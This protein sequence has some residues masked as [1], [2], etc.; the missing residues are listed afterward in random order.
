MNGNVDIAREK[1]TREQLSSTGVDSSLSPRKGDNKMSLLL[2]LVILI[3]IFGGGGMFYGGGRYR[4][5][6]LGLGGI[7]LIVLI[8]LLLTRGFGGGPVL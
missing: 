7:L 3:L 4:N 1:G 8:I 5:H 2:V 6:G